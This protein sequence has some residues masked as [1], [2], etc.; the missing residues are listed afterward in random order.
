MHAI[1]PQ[2]NYTT[3][4]WF[5]IDFRFSKI[6]LFVTYLSLSSQLSTF[7]QIIKKNVHSLHVHV[8]YTN[9]ASFEALLTL[10]GFIA[11]NVLCQP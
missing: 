4:H 3:L 2:Q 10:A 6:P 9:S 1:F 11:V 8:V 7:T 5:L